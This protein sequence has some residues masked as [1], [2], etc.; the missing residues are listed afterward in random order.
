MCSGSVRLPDLHELVSDGSP[1]TVEDAAADEDAFTDGVA[2]AVL[3]EVPIGGIDVGVTEDRTDPFGAF[4]IDMPQFATRVTQA[5]A[6]VWG[7]V[8]ERLRQSPR[9]PRLLLCDRGVDVSLISR[10]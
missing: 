4:G 3:G 8:E 5:S 1:V 2:V 6:G 9:R 10:R 7:E